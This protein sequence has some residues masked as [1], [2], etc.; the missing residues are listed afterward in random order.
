L[1]FRQVLYRDLG[2]ASYMLGDAG[3]AVVVDP[4]WDIDVYLEIAR[5]E[6]LRITHVLDTHDHADHVS[7]RIRLA[8]ATGAR[9]YRATGPGET[10]EDRF[11]P[12]QVIAVGSLRLDAIATPGHRPEH[13]SLTVADLSRASEPWVLL[14][15]DS[16]LV[17]D[18]ARPDLSYE[19]IEG[20]R[21]LHSSLQHLLA[22]GD[23]VE[24]WPAH[25]GGSLCGG[26]GLSGKTSS[27]VGFERRQN[28]MLHMGEADF[29]NGLTSNL[30]SRPPNVDRI[31][32]LNQRRDGGHP[33]EPPPLTA[34]RLR[35]LLAAGVTVLDSRQPDEFDAG[36]LAAAVNL[37]VSAPGVGTRAGWA[38]ESGA[39]IV[40]VAKDLDAARETA[41]ALQ[42]VGLWEL[43]GYT[44]AHESSWE[45]NGLPIAQAHS[46]DLDQLAHGLR[47]D[48]VELVDVR[49]SSE[50]VCGHVAGSHHVPLRRLRDVASVRLPDRGRTTAVVCAAGIRAAFAASLFRRAGRRDVVRVAGGGVGDL[51]SRG[52]P[53]A[54][55]AD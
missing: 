43:A 29:V 15:G 13:L 25:V 20:A 11:H 34:D 9:V 21:T 49:E 19:A 44:L 24:V 48:S 6:R 26:A 38:L 32:A 4:R 46:W 12:G 8:Q 3:E 2:C 22:L 28:P 53:L 51:S 1:F 23:H 40:I 36:H 41:S 39:Q 5:T 33:A 35:E 30:P 31:V 52:I 27:T 47:R 16:L 55:G 10:R 42:A 50:W 7:G 18:L 45:R 37:P 54:V 14:A 17:G